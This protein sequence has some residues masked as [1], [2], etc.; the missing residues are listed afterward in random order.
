MT[1]QISKW[2]TYGESLDDY[3]GGNALVVAQ[4][5]KR[6]SHGRLSRGSRQNQVG[7]VERV[8]ADQDLLELFGEIA[9]EDVQFAIRESGGVLNERAGNRTQAQAL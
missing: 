3:S 1:G 9:W 5:G 7:I 8:F 6:D 4:H 2:G